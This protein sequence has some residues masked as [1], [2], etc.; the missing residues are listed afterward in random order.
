MKNN[1]TFL[2]KL[3][4]G[5]EVE[6]KPLKD[7]L[8]RT[9]GT[10]I[11]AAEMKVLHKDNAP[12]K[13]FAGGKTF[14][15]VNFEDIPEKDINKNPSI[16][17]KSR[18]I[19]EFE[20]YDKPFS[21]KNE[22]WS[23]Y[24]NDKNINIKYIYY[25]LKN[26][27][28]YFQNLGSKMQMPQIATPDTDKYLVPIPPLSVQTEIVKILDALTALTSELILRQKQYE[29][30]REKLLNIDEMNKVIE[31]GDVGPV[32]MCKRILKNQTASSGD[33]PFY[34]I[35]TFG[36]KPDAYISNELFQEYKQKYSYPK[37]G[38]IL[39][40]ASG[41]IGRTV[42]FDGENSYFQDSNIVWIDNDETL[43]LNKY[44]YHFYKIAKWGIAEGGT[45]QRLYN[46]NL[47]KVKISIPPLK[48]QHRIVSILDK[49]E[50][51]TN[52]I[53]EGLPLAIEQSQ[54]R[55]EYYRKLL[56]NFS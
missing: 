17:V 38:D 14:A 5:A 51:L 13:I 48:E 24:S 55:Y 39:I 22:M 52:S 45:I 12:L 21:H 37:K 10:K 18:G 46:D 33:I 42:I 25:V 6:W 40:S 9:K 1:R 2:E 49:F 16:I 4:D 7:I 36:K 8:I 27:E 35:G 34:K 20:Y 23:Y 15:L 26:Q 54:K 50:T 11:T 32:R 53:T 47:K 31:L 41:T 30:Y 56:L 28:P 19:I 29:Y 3:L 44:L 43:V